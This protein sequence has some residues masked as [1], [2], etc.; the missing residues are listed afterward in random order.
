MARLLGKLTAD[1]ESQKVGVGSAEGCGVAD[2][3]QE[4]L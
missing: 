3:G 4:P 1:W 2:S